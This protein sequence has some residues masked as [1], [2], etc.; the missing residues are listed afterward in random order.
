MEFNIF[1]VLLNKL[2][3]FVTYYDGVNSRFQ[4]KYS[5][6]IRRKNPTINIYKKGIN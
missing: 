6:I 3:D 5:N 2:I 4:K 1:G